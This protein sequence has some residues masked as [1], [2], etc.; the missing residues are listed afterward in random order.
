MNQPRLHRRIS[1]VASAAGMLLALSSPVGVRADEGREDADAGPP[2]GP[3]AA[4]S[5]SYFDR[6]IFGNETPVAVRRE[7]NVYLRRK[8]AETDLI[9]GLSERQKQK[10][11]LAGRGDLKRLFDRIDESRRKLMNA[12]ESEADAILQK[13]REDAEALKAA[14]RSEPFEQ[15][16]LL[17]KTWA[18][19]LTPEQ[20]ARRAAFA[21]ADR[22]TGVHFEPA[23][24][25]H[26]NLREVRFP[27]T[28]F[29]D[30][31][32]A[33]LRRMATLR[34]IVLDSTRITD[35]G[36]AHLA[37]LTN[38]EELDLADTRI[39]GSGLAHLRGPGSLR[40]LDLRRTALN[41]DNLV[42]LEEQ[43]NLR[44]LYLQE[45]PVTDAGL[46][47]LTGL[48][49]LRELYLRGTPITDAGLASL[50]GLVNLRQLD[51]DG[52]QITDAGLESLVGLNKLE[53]LDLRGTQV[54]DAGLPR[55][56]AL[57]ELRHVYLFD[58]AVT[59]AGVAG[60]RDNLPNVKVL[61]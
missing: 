40:S 50:K 29:G 10:L 37:G 35:A 14:V 59:K 38:L 39:D 33:R 34:K 52:T 17:S 27:A 58:T 24:K 31:D 11:Q 21:A 41:G 4:S 36:L 44:R 6:L 3:V 15:G 13:L 25:E 5:A 49:E 61:R 45:T 42:Y 7:L 60:L 1:L 22:I 19:T 18:R 32:L 51:L 12:D 46:A 55:L 28:P 57:P 47:H 54:T 9:C 20:A 26:D 8:I 23:S 30:A 2:A 48:T 53:V 43:T 16:S 56:A